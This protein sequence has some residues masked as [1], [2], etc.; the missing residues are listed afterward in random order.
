MEDPSV[1]DF[2]THWQN[3]MQAKYATFKRD[4]WYSFDDT[5]ALAIKVCKHYN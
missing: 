1:T 5:E 3:D 2:E 4:Q